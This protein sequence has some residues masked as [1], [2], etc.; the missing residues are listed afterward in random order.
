MC[1]VSHPVCDVHDRGCREPCGARAGADTRRPRARRI[2]RPAA[3]VD[4]SGGGEMG[5]IRAWSAA[6]IGPL[7]L[8]AGPF[9]QTTD[10]GP[11]RLLLDI[12][13]KPRPESGSSAREFVRVV[14]IVI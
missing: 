14:D 13:T 8:I 3:A 7:F 4:M 5:R 9:A 1:R 11:A 12:N 2:L 10:S 6:L